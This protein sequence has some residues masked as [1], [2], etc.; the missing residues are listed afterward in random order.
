MLG[1]TDYF[2]RLIPANPILLRVVETGGKRKRDLLIRC[3]YLGLLIIVVLFSLYSN[4]SGNVSDTNLAELAKTSVK[5]FQNL[6]YLQLGLVALLS[7]IFTA[8][9]ITQEKDSQTYDILLAT[10]L[11]N[12]QIVLGSL[13]SR[14]FFVVI[15]LVSGIPIFAITQ[16]FGGVAI[17]NIFTSFLIAA[18]TAFVTGALAMAIATFKVGTRRTIFS[19]YFFIV[20][21]LVG[22]YFLDQ[23]S[24]FHPIIGYTPDPA[25]ARNLIPTLSTTSWLTGLNPFTALQTLFADKD[26]R[27]PALGLLPPDLQRW[28]FGWYISSP[29]SFYI[30]LMFFLSFILVTPSVILLRWLAQ[31]NMPFKTWILTKLHLSTGDRTRKP[32]YVWSNPIAWRE[33]K[34]KA[35]ATKASMLRYGFMLVGVLGALGLVYEFSGLEEP[36]NY[37]RADS[38]DPATGSITVYDKLS[39]HHYQVISNSNVASN[40]TTLTFKQKPSDTEGRTATPADLHHRYAVDVQVEENNALASM[41]IWPIPH[42]ISEENVRNYLLASVVLEFAVILLI[43][44]NAAASTVTREKEDGTLDLLLTTPITSRYYIWGKLRG[45]VYFV[46]PL[47]AVPVASCLVFI[48]YDLMRFTGDSTERWIAFPESL[49]LLPC[50]LIIIAAFAAILGMQMSLRMRTTVMAVMSSV[51]IVVGACG[52]LGYCGYSFLNYRDS[53]GFAVF[54]GSFSPF[55][56]MTMLINPYQFDRVFQGDDQSGNRVWMFL[57]TAAA[58]AAYTSIVFAL[59]RSMVKNFDMTIRRQ[60]R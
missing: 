31:T 13:L 54:V 28:P 40:N 14:L 50:M 20:I 47:I 32:R 34:T 12:G 9:S 60:Q 3:A 21:Y 56:L 5:V 25:N 46:L 17:S 4:G 33:A 37:I 41:I 52:L 2:Y 10:P 42:K 18:A 43:V 8:G 26:S 49:V 35:S 55:T 53:G 51:G 1:I 23:I 24:W 19:F 44:T 22:L 39:A 16:I 59:Y 30:S 45:L 27:P 58:V 36:T 29:S 38:Y 48:C 15:L 7:P 57:S 11:S 6:S